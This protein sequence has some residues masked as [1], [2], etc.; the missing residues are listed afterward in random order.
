MRRRAKI[1]E[2]QPE[3][4]AALRAVPGLTVQSLAAVGHGIPDLLVGYAGRNYLLEVKNPLL[5]PSKQRLTDDERDWH[6]AW[7]GQ[8]CTVRT[9][10]EA[11]RA[12]GAPSAHAA[13]APTAERERSDPRKPACSSGA[14]NAPTGKP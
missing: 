9:A 3:I 12:V 6:A 2:N 8:V 11:L 4:V 5:V 13:A 1:D 14:A 10:G 7:T